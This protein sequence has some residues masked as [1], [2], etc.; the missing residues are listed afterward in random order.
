MAMNISDPYT[1]MI[2]CYTP[3]VFPFQSLQTLTL[4]YILVISQGVN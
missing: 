3:P 1:Q 4:L 2:Y